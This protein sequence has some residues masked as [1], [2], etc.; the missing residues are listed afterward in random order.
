MERII[1][2]NWQTLVKEA[3]ARRKAQHLTQKQLAV[4]AQ[5]SHPV[6]NNFEQGKTEITLSSAMKILQCLGL[7]EV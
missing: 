4:L 6:V 5:V 7:L 1:R 3:I 2:L